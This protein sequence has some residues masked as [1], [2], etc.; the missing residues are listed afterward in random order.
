MDRA[1]SS[2]PPVPPSAS[3]RTSRVPSQT[4]IS[5][6]P[7]SAYYPTPVP[8]PLSGQRTSPP[9]PTRPISSASTYSNVAIAGSL[10][11]HYGS[12]TSGNSSDTPSAAVPPIP[13]AASLANVSR[14]LST[15]DAAKVV[16]L[17][18]QVPANN[19]I[20]LPSNHNN[21]L[22][23]SPTNPYG[24][25][26]ISFATTHTILDEHPINP[27]RNS[28]PSDA[29]W[30]S[31]CI[32]T[33]PLFNGRGA[34][35]TI[36]DINFLVT[37]WLQMLPMTNSHTPAHILGCISE[38]INTGILSLWNKVMSMR[39]S[40]TEIDPALL[41]HRLAESWRLF[42]G[43]VVPLLE[44]VFLPLR[45]HED[46]ILGGGRTLGMLRTVD[47]RTIAL[48]AF[49]DG[50]I[51]SSA[52]G[53]GVRK[54]QGM[55]AHIH[56]KHYTHAGMLRAHFY[57]TESVTLLLAPRAPPPN[58]SISKINETSATLMQMFAILTAA[59]H[60]SSGYK[61]IKDLSQYYKRRVADWIRWVEEIEEREER[62][63]LGR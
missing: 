39:S 33:L 51:S 16:L 3:S 24:P 35:G 44:G 26:N 12:N 61:P 37:N 55:L 58:S 25:A 27:Q 23:P 42:F 9:R 19:S 53:I 13:S 56:L 20:G 49:R 14:S 43:T 54:L 21:T 11:S 52:G 30:T 22:L 29:M 17:Q 59:S 32:R 8:S 47:V 57:A 4:P 50:L 48:K 18:I 1:R 31:I 38:M 60:G 45:L 2:S 6:R 34:T 40:S 36:E 28:I 10:A 63:I 46:L 5:H 62:A 7:V 41:A 15:L